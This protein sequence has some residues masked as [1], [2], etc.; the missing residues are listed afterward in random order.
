M[1][2][3][4]IVDPRQHCRVGSLSVGIDREGRDDRRAVEPFQSKLALS[5][6]RSF[7]GAPS[8]WRTPCACPLCEIVQGLPPHW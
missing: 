8:T 2:S 3:E 7:R 1:E 5:R 6:R 4:N